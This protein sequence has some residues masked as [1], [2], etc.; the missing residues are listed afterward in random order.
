MN[1]IPRN[2]N[3]LCPIVRNVE[4]TNGQHDYFQ[5]RGCV[6]GSCQARLLESD[7]V[8]AK[9]KEVTIGL[10]MVRAPQV[11][12]SSGFALSTVPPAIAGCGSITVRP[13]FIRR[14]PKKRNSSVVFHCSPRLE[15]LDTFSSKFVK[16]RASLRILIMMCFGFPVVLRVDSIQSQPAPKAPRFSNSG[17]VAPK[18]TY[19]ATKCSQYKCVETKRVEKGV[20]V[21]L[22]ML[23]HGLLSVSDLVCLFHTE[24]PAEAPGQCAEVVVL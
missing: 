5:V 16:G 20:L 19:I 13:F 14:Q 22:H 10:G 15:R 23:R 8:A 24:L 9:S 21:K 18:K 11:L 1:D 7:I 3:C 17:G 12:L 4:E 6:V 2:R